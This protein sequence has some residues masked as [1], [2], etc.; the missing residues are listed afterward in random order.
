MKS[1]LIHHHKGTIYQRDVNEVL[2][3]LHD[4]I[5]HAIEDFHSTGKV[6]HL[7]KPQLVQY[8]NSL[9][10]DDHQRAEYIA[11]GVKNILDQVMDTRFA[12]HRYYGSDI[13][14]HYSD[15]SKEVNTKWK[16]WIEGQPIG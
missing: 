4:M 10:I 3:D 6:K 9:A 13:L 11:V 12:P 1:Y 7:L 8:R 2:H 15:M 16:M 14:D 5:R